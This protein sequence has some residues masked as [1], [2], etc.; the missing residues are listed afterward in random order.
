LD[1]IGVVNTL[2]VRNGI[3]MDCGGA[4]TELI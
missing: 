3:I 4:S 2:P 1:Y